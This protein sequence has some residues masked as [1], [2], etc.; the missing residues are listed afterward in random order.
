MLRRG[1][2]HCSVGLWCET[3]G[4]WVAVLFEYGSP[5]SAIRQRPDLFPSASIRCC[6]KCREIVEAL[7]EETDCRELFGKVLSQALIQR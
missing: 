7:P 5:D 6:E 4:K 1:V 3:C 2:V